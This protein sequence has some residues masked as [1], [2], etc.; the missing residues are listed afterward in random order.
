MSCQ[1]VESARAVY[2]TLVVGF[3]C[4]LACVGIVLAVRAAAGR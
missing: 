4:A 3:L 2:W 1:P